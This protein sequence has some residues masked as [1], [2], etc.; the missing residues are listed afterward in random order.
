MACAVLTSN[1]V[2]I[3]GVP[4]TAK[5]G[6]TVGGAAAAIGSGIWCL[7][8]GLWR[9]LRRSPTTKGDLNANFIKRTTFLY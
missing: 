6:V 8:E 4:F 7:P 5:V 1:A 9:P 2:A 3:T